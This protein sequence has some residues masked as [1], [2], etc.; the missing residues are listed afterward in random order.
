MKSKF[1]FLLILLILSGFWCERAIGADQFQDV[2]FFGRM[3]V[4]PGYNGM[5]SFKVTHDSGNDSDQIKV[6]LL[7]GGKDVAIFRRDSEVGQEFVSN[8]YFRL[9]RGV[10]VV[11]IEWS[12]GAVSTGLTI[13]GLDSSGRITKMFDDSC[14]D[15]FQFVDLDGGK[16][17]NIVAVDRLVRKENRYR[18]H[19]FSLA[20]GSFRYE[21]TRSVVTKS[22]HLYRL[23][24]GLA[25]QAQGK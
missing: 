21:E 8:A 23:V 7:R 4:R 18:A 9:V 13:Y 17:M 24:T 22:P 11:C 6:E 3:S 10:P 12:L 20:A 15:G 19:I 1:Y 25:D 5:L 16:T 2:R 14:D